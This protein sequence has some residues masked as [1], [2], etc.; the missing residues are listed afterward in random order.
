MRLA[1]RETL[2]LWSVYSKSS[3]VLVRTFPITI[4]R[5]LEKFES[6]NQII[7]HFQI[8]SLNHMWMDRYTKYTVYKKD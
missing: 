3:N 8:H 2:K 5:F 1:Q 4:T 7:N 6:N